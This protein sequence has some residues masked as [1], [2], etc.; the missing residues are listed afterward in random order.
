MERMVRHSSNTSELWKTIPWKKFRANLF[1]LQ[2]RVYKAVSVGNKRKARS[3]QKLILKSQAARLLAIRQV[4]E[5]NAG[6]KTAG[7]NGKSSLSIK[8]RIALSEQLR[9]GLFHSNQ[10][11]SVPRLWR[12]STA[13]F[14]WLRGKDSSRK[15]GFWADSVNSE[16]WA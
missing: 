7:I 15:S 3:L 1:R 8:E 12:S 2:R 14:F 5:L 10:T 13:Y 6:K 11:P 16:L 9:P 4:T